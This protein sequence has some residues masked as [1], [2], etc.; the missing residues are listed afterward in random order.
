M[1]LPAWTV[2]FGP[3]ALAAAI[4]PLLIT[5]LAVAV[6]AATDRSAGKVGAAAPAAAAATQPPSSAACSPLRHRPPATGGLALEAKVSGVLNKNGEQT[7]RRLVLTTRAG[8]QVAIGLPS[9]SFVAQPAADWLVYGLATRSGSDVRAVDLESGCDTRLARLSGIA[10]GA[11]LDQAASGLY[12][13]FVDAATRADAGVL[14]VDLATGTATPV[15]SPFIPA[16][17]F[18]PVFATQLAWSLDGATLAVQSC[19]AIGCQTR[20][21]DAATGAVEDVSTI[22]GALVGV[23]DDQVYAFEAGHDRPATLLAYQ[24]GGG[25]MSVVATDVH[26]A[27]LIGP[28][29]APVLSYETSAGWQE[30]QP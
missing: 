9:D 25:E 18:G 8:R 12:V 30:V 10:R 6:P 27:E 4:I 7:G 1:G 22:H 2:R 14:H 13:H 29:E 26:A 15:L 19:G 24:R 11:V 20:L 21:L 5:G 28:P 17:E 23:T 3:P 16:A